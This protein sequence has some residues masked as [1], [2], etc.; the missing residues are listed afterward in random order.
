VSIWE[1]IEWTSKLI[2]GPG[3]GKF[4]AADKRITCLHCGHDTF[5]QGATVVDALTD[6]HP[7]IA[8]GTSAT[9]LICDDYGRIEL[10]ARHPE[11]ER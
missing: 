9:A 11:R 8:F 2:D 7:D 10:F 4:K 6:S 5:I 3:P 1:S